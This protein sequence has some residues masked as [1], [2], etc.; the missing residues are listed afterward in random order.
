[1][2]GVSL[3]VDTARS[4]HQKGGVVGINARA[5]EREVLRR[6][7][8]RYAGFDIVEDTWLIAK[9]LS[10]PENDSETGRHDRS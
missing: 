2:K 8:E 6:S 3:V 7:R 5:I 10:L 4:K 9:V 1:L